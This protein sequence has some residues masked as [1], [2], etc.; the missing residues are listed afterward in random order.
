MFPKL[1]Y[2]QD[3]QRCKALISVNEHTQPPTQRECHRREFGCKL[4]WIN[5][6]T[7]GRQ[8]D[9]DAESSRLRQGLEAQNP[10]THTLKLKSKNNRTQHKKKKNRIQRI[11]ARQ[12]RGT[13]KENDEFY[14][15]RS[16]NSSYQ[17]FGTSHEIHRN[18]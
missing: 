13:P 5:R 6:E 10:R 4:L 16:R 17:L 2:L 1:V 7:R 14:F 15:N 8:A 9:A 3:G 18:S 12:L 11:E